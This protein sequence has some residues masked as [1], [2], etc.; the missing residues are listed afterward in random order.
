MLN[1]DLAI[2]FITKTGKKKFSEVWDH[3]KDDLFLE[4]KTIKK[5][6]NIKSDFFISM[7]NDERLIMI[8]DDT[9][10]LKGKYSL[11]E[12][13][14]INIKVFGNQ[15]EKE[16]SEELLKDNDLTLDE[17]EEEEIDTPSI[18][19]EIEEEEN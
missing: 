9:W 2:D 16:D 17:D 11:S 12:I 6:A 13:E 4:I 8:G 14:D 5:E 19:Q 18:Y 1:V 15:I 3:V 7:M 10:D